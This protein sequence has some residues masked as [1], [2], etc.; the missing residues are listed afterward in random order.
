MYHGATGQDWDNVIFRKPKPKVKKPTPSADGNGLRKIDRQE[1]GTHAKVTRK[2]GSAIARARV[3][4]GLSQQALAGAIRVRP[5]VI[6]DYEAGRAQ[7]DN[8][9][10]QRLRS[11]LGKLM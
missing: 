11:V 3:R 5:G 7:R 9:I 1:V 2:E 6:K 4:K 10:M 8:A